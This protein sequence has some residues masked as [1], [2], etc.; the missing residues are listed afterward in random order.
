MAKIQPAV[1]TMEFVVPESTA[2]QYI[3]LWHCASIVNRRFYRAG[4]NM[5]VAGFTVVADNTAQAGSI[6]LSKLPNTWCFSASWMKAFS[7]WKRQQDEALDESDKQSVKGR[8][9]DF[10]IF[11]DTD[12]AQAAAP[13]TLIPVD[14]QPTVPRTQFLPSEEWLYSEV[15]IP[16]DAAPGVTTSVALHAVGDDDLAVPSYGIIKAYSDSRSVPQ[17]PDPAVT[18]FTQVTSGLY[19]TMWDVGNDDEE[20][21]TAA[22]FRNDELPYDQTEYPGGAVN[23]PT[24]ELIHDLVLNPASSIPATF[25]LSGTN[26]PCGLLRIDADNAGAGIPFNL[27]V[28][29][30]PG[31]HRGYMAEPMQDM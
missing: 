6:T 21:I 5:A 30:V 27:L 2:P 11:M 28:H 13:Y 23:A 24:T 25:K 17:S 8:F 3:D 1:Y 18:G 26:L 31:T 12:H 7:S 29:L 10:K 20:I 4:Y 15:H 19:S 22:A 9:N 14:L 16:N